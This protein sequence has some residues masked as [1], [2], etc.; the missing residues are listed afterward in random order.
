MLHIKK[1]PVFYIWFQSVLKKTILQ[2]NFK[3]VLLF[4]ELKY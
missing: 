3:N 1:N 4:I 2:I